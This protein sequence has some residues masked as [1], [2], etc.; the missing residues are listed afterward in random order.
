MNRFL[1]FLALFA[2]TSPIHAQLWTGVIAPGRA[3]DWSRAGVGPIPAREKICASLTASATLDEINRALAAC[4]SGEV[5][6]LAAGTYTIP[7]TI[8]VP[9]RVT[10][11]GA[12]ADKT[13]L[14]TTG[15]GRAAIQ[16]GSGEPPWRPALIP[17]TGGAEAGSTTI[18]LSS[19][20]DV[21]KGDLLAIGERNNPDFVSSEGNEGLCGWCDGGWSATGDYARGQVVAVTGVNGNKVTIV[22]GLYG[23][24]TNSPV[25]VPFRASVIAAGVEDL[26]VYANNTGYGTAF[27]MNACAY[28][29]IKGVEANYTDGDHVE[30]YWG[31]HDEVRDSYFS[32]A[33]LHTPGAHDSDIALGFKTSA[34]LVENNI[35]ERTHTS[36]MLEWGAA[37]NVIA[38]NYTMG[39]FHYAPN[40]VIGGIEF[41][42]AHPQYNLLEGNVL[43]I[44]SLDSIWGSSSHSTVFRNWVI[45]TNHICEPAQGRGPVSCT[46]SNGHYGFQA[47]RAIQVSYLS[48]RNNFIGNVIGSEQ[49]RNL[50]EEYVYNGRGAPLAQVPV[51]E[52]P[53]LLTYDRSAYGFTIGYGGAGDGGVGTGCGDREPPCHRAGTSKTDL[54]HG[55]YLNPDGS[56]RWA[57]NVSH[58]LPASFY[59]S[60]KPAWWGSLPYPAT[61]PD[62]SGGAGPGGHS[63]GNP[64]QRCYFQ[65]MGGSDGGAGS[66]RTFNSSSCY[67]EVK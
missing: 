67:R 12:G 30:I 58:D 9:S 4:K 50:R 34:S 25:V 42:G 49:M 43:T 20:L 11:R 46:G 61:G 16:M 38:Y 52:Y 37:G 31:Y 28:C 24:Y 22:P 8:Q 40:F 56:T 29:W 6:F 2:A 59:L 39:E 1:L 32:N 44:I 55:N 10:L 53:E 18:E 27:G 13:I 21:H 45:G 63:F 15:K 3:I 54:F 23:A 51:A 19:T 35:I 14:S 17:I 47:A 36:I 65:I 33:Y 41:H 7:G 60:A 26:Q 62:V 66:P 5:V 57:P 64:A 48:V